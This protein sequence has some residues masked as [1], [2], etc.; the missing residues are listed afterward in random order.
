MTDYIIRRLLLMIPTLFLV[1]VIIFTILRIIPG[2]VA[3]LIA[4]RGGEG[5]A[6]QE[7][8]Q[9]IREKLGLG[10]PLYVQYAKFMGGLLKMD[11]GNSLWSGRPVIEELLT[12]LPLTIELA[13]LSIIVSVS[14][15]I[16]IGV[17]SAIRQDTWVD[18]LFRVIS[19]TGLAVPNFWLGVLI[20]LFLSVWFH[21]IP[22]L[23]YSDFF[24]D[25]WKNVQQM[26]WPAIALG[27][28]LSAIVSRMTRSTMLEVLREDYIRTA[29]AKGLRERVVIFRHALKNALLPVITIAGLQLGAL[30]G[31]TVIA[32][33]IFTLPGVGRF[34]IDSINHRDYPVVQTIVMWL[35]V[36]FS[37]LNLAV[38][39]AYGWLN[40]R[41][42]YH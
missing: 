24:V 13:L 12:R 33:T 35:A 22:P 42:R 14:I 28:R 36:V 31:G 19:I 29:W 6:T 16:P 17:L 40:P 23:G 39:V 37:T 25:P 5:I 26:I 32:E 41:I 21:W 15:A 30:L 1:S 20:I 10:D 18:Y 8:I 2:D 4:T 7:E 11:V 38:D 27:Y 34:L 9:N 3:S